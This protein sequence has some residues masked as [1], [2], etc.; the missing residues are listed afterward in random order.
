MQPALAT[1]R[2]LRVT[3]E[4]RLTVEAPSQQ[5]KS[6]MAPAPVYCSLP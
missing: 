2:R 5:P 4:A 6:T 1:T 3:P